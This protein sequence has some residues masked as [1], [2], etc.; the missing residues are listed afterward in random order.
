VLKKH[1][2]FIIIITIGLITLISVFSKFQDLSRSNRELKSKIK[3][4][5]VENKMLARRQYKLETDPV[6]AESV[7]REKLHLLKEDEVIYKIFSEEE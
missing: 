2:F 4:L 1:R 3:Q 6:F 7:A 5:I